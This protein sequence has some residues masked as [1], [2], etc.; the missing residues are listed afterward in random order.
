MKGHRS[1]TEPNDARGLTRHALSTQAR[2]LDLASRSG[3]AECFLRR[4]V[5]CSV[6][7]EGRAVTNAE[8]VVR[9]EVALRVL[10]N[11]QVG[12]WGGSIPRC[13]NAVAD[14]VARAEANASCGRAAETILADSNVSHQVL[15]ELELPEPRKIIS[16]VDVF[17]AEL[18]MQRPH[19]LWSGQ[20]SVVRRI[21]RVI[22]SE[23]LEAWSISSEFHWRLRGR[24]PAN[25]TPVDRLLEVRAGR[26]S[27]ATSMLKARIEAEF[28]VREDFMGIPSDISITLGPSVVA[29]LCLALIPGR[30]THVS[31]LLDGR[32]TI[33]D[34]PGDCYQGCDDEG[35]PIVPVPLVVAGRPGSPWAT[36]GATAPPTGRGMRGAIDSAPVL[37]SL[38]LRWAS[39]GDAPL[40]RSVLISELAGISL[41]ADGSVQGTAP[42]GVVLSNGKPIRRCPGRVVRIAAVDALGCRLAGISQDRF[43]T[44]RHRLPSVTLA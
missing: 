40:T 28:P 24:C 32:V 11:G 26:W 29:S 19:F 25:R 9:T 7:F 4:V 21:G 18:Q 1:S 31:S 44:G 6:R 20:V 30:V 15:P 23:G 5:S 37:T 3:P 22:H 35:V 42:E 34:D 41:Q 13:E 36:V 33:W 43:A 8:E 27:E 12:M 2:L 38:G 10:R 17:L 39:G 16:L 14:G